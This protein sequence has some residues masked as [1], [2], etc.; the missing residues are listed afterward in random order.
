MQQ[1]T[2]SE[3]PRLVSATP[4]DGYKL[5][6]LYNNGERRVF[7]ASPLMAHKVF[8]PLA[9]KG[10]FGLVKV[11]FDTVIWPRDIDYCPDRLYEESVPY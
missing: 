1:E 5:L 10:F 7:D 3:K 4:S 8:A 6:L 9:N 2:A 11:E